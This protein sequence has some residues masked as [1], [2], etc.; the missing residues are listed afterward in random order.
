MTNKSRFSG[1]LYLL[2]LYLYCLDQTQK[3]ELIPGMSQ[4]GVSKYGLK[5]I[6]L[7]LDVLLTY[8]IP[9]LIYQ[10]FAGFG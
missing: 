7:Y 8:H 5:Q 3:E 4:G 10:V 6:F 2:L 1:T 9:Q